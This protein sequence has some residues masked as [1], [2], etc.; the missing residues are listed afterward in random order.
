MGAWNSR[1]FMLRI[2]FVGIKSC[3]IRLS[4]GTQAERKR[5]IID[6]EEVSDWP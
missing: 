5:K 4:T 1:V 2:W 6:P 3:P